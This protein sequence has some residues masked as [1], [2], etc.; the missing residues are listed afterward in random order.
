VRRL[1]K[2]ALDHVVYASVGVG[3]TLAAWLKTV[4]GVVRAPLPLCTTTVLADKQL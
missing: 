2:A 4:T 1:N 3:L